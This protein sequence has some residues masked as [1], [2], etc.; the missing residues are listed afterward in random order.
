MNGCFYV[1]MLG[2]FLSL[3][4]CER[5]ARVTNDG[6]TPVHVSLLLISTKQ[7][8][9]NEWA[10]QTFEATNP[11]IDIVIEQFP[12]SSLKDFEIKL[13]LRFASGQPPDMF[14]INQN[15]AAEFARLDLLAEAP[16]YIENR[17]QS[18][19]LNVMIRNAPYFD[20][21][22]FGIVSEAVWTVLYYNKD[23][24]IE[25]GLNPERPPKTWDELIEYADRLTIRDS[26]GR[27]IRAGISLRKT[28]F[29]PGTAEKW[30]TFL[31]SASGSPF[32]DD[33]TQSTFNS[34]AGRTALDLYKTILFDKRIDAVE[35][36]GDQQGFGQQKAAMFIREP[37]VIR[38]LQ[39]NYPDLS[40]GVAPI[41]AEKASVSAGSSYM[42]VVSKDSPHQQAAWRFVDFLV[43][44]EVYEIYVSIGGILPD[45]ASIASLPQYRDDPYLRVFFDQGVA[46]ISSFPRFDRAVGMLGA[47]IERFCY[48]HLNTD[49]TLRR[50]ARDIDALLS[51]NRQRNR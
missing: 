33:G 22:C 4:G 9:F 27:P 2:V 51:R 12:G 49:E 6:R 48:G 26:E 36:E 44:D 17:V 40:F 13:R 37:H 28:G 24:F 47:Y 45:T 32:N 50:A 31:Y 34:Q 41:P 7:V 11:D 42:L 15:V 21:T 19:S 5:S 20:G 39:E 35:L 8:A 3:S 10:E 14:H 1:V 29:K 38:W 30:F 43:D 46:P 25:A 23:M 18:N 16:P